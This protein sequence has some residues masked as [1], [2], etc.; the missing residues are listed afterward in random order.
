MQAL[1]LYGH[2][3]APYERSEILSYPEVWFLGR[4]D[5]SRAGARAS[6]PPP[7]S[8]APEAEASPSSRATRR[9][10]RGWDTDRGEYVVSAGDHLAYRYEVESELG[11]GSFGVVL[12]CR[13]WADGG[14]PAAVK[15]MRSSRR[16]AKQAAVEGSILS[17]LAPYVAAGQAAIVKS[18]GAFS[19]RGHLCVSFEVLALNLYEHLQER[20]MVGCGEG[21]VRR[22]TEQVLGA[23]RLL[24]SLDVV[25]CDVKPENLMLVDRGRLDVR[26]IDFG[27]ACYREQQVYS[28]VQSRFYRAP[29]VILGQRYGPAIDAWSL[30]CVASELRTGYPLFPGEDEHQQLAYIVEVIGRPPRDFLAQCSR[31]NLFFDSLGNPLPCLVTRSGKRA[32]PGGRPLEALLAAHQPSAAFLAFLKAVLRWDPA[33]RPTAEK[34]LEHEWIA[35]LWR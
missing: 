11:R 16:L 6:P 10:R 1:E 5:A 22:V 27:S 23:L 25:H 17:R 18:A 26:L 30:A 29:E 24:A 2:L 33:E 35:D 28:Y 7:A 14:R 19:F 4:P 8:G 20:K 32:T 21:A 12:R 9:P 3:L 34:L 15:V 31:A 13:D